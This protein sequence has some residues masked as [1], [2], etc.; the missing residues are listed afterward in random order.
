[1]LNMAFYKF[2][3]MNFRNYNDNL[4]LVNNYPIEYLF[5]LDRHSICCIQCK[6]NFI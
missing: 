3:K 6:N 2:Y 5:T 1:M 4:N